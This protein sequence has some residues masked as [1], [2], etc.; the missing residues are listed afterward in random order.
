MGVEHRHGGRDF[1]DYEDQ[2]LNDGCPL[3]MIDFGQQGFLIHM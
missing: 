2:F 3:P 1:A